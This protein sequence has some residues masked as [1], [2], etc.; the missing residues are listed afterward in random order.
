M[1]NDKQRKR[2]KRIKRRF[3]QRGKKSRG[4]IKEKRETKRED[5]KKLLSDIYIKQT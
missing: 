4:I 1:T 5:S 3:K 2:K